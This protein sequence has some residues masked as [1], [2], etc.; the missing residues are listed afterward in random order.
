MRIVPTQNGEQEVEECGTCGN[1]CVFTYKTF[2]NC[3]ETHCCEICSKHWAIALYTKQFY[4]DLRNL[5][6][7]K[8]IG[9]GWVTEDDTDI[10]RID[11]R[12]RRTMWFACNRLGTELAT[13]ILNKAMKEYWNEVKGHWVHSFRSESSS[14]PL[15]IL[16][17]QREDRAGP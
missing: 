15:P 14:L 1:E 17:R 13:M 11:K 8:G 16:R 2:G 4:L 5:V 12:I 9:N 10:Y 6:R 3:W 7:A